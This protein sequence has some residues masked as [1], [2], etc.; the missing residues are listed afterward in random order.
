MI[1]TRRSQPDKPL[2]AATQLQRR[3]FETYNLAPMSV[4]SDRDLKAKWL[5]H[6]RQNNLS[7]SGLIEAFIRS[8]LK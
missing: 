2:S 1:R 6:T 5:E 8:Q 4:Y 7:T 3:Y